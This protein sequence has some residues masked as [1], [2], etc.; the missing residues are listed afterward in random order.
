[1]T[2]EDKRKA[3][4]DGKARAVNLGGICMLEVNWQ[5]EWAILRK[6]IET[7]VSKMIMM[8]RKAQSGVSAM[9][10]K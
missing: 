8:A 4:T 10:E 5:W 1:M 3:S 6:R 7:I 9:M 2:A